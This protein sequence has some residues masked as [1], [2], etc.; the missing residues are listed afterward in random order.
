[1]PYYPNF[2]SKD[3]AG[4]TSAAGGQGIQVYSYNS[5]APNLPKPWLDAVA[6]GKYGGFADAR[7]RFKKNYYGDSGGRAEESWRHPTPWG[8]MPHY[9]RRPV[10]PAPPTG[11]CGGHADKGGSW[12]KS[13]PGSVNCYKEQ[14]RAA[15]VKKFGMHGDKGGRPLFSK[16][17]EQNLRDWGYNLDRLHKLEHKYKF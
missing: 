1:M 3:P 11:D 14:I 12:C 16:R 5:N 4:L 6:R 2:L 7:L 10:I 15:Q 8:G 13:L 9:V 17:E